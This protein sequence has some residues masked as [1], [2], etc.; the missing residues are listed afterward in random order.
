MVL[1]LVVVVAVI[2]LPF[3]LP[4]STYAFQLILYIAVAW[5]KLLETVSDSVTLSELQ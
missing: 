1:V 5:I 3:W 2:K 4:Y